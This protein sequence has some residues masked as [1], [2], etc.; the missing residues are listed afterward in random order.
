MHLSGTR[1]QVPPAPN[2]ASNAPLSV[3]LEVIK[4]LHDRF[5]A[6]VTEWDVRDATDAKFT[7]NVSVQG[8]RSGKVRA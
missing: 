5:G 8:S 2:P 1:P 3:G 7:L 4:L 6:V